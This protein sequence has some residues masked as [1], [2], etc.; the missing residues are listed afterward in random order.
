MCDLKVASWW[1]QDVLLQQSSQHSGALRCGTP[2]PHAQVKGLDVIPGL[3]RDLESS[4]RR[5]EEL[6]AERDGLQVLATA[7][8]TL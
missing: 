3:R 2:E 6:H 5:I 4:A 8:V 7:F 1:P